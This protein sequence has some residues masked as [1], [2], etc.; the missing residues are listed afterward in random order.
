[1]WSSDAPPEA[2]EDHNPCGPATHRGPV[3]ARVCEDGG[4]AEPSSQSSQSSRRALRIVDN[5]AASRYELTVDGEL[6]GFVTYRDRPDAARIALHTEVLPEF[7]GHGLAAQL[8]HFVLNDIRERGMR[9]V[10]RCPYVAQYIRKH[11]EYADLV[12]G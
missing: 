11:P 3:G 8:A 5:A 12:A 6:A 2:S 10:A 9:V 4:V 7:E 1:M